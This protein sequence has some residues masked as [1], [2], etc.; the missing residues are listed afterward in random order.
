MI[1]PAKEI[2]QYLE[3]Q[4]PWDIGGSASFSLYMNVEPNEPEN[5]VTVYDTP[6]GTLDTDELDIETPNFQVRV[7]CKKHSDG[8]AV[9]VAIRDLLVRTQPIGSFIGVVLNDGIHSSGRDQNLRHV[10]TANYRTIR[11]IT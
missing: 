8:Y 6:G 7:R 1:S 9:Q 2:A 3:A 4:G 10:L 11:K 5:V